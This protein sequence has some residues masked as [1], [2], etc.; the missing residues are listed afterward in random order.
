MAWTP[1]SMP[2]SRAW[3]SCI[4]GGGLF[5]AIA[6]DSNS[7]AYSLNGTQWTGA[8]T[9][10]TFNC[11]TNGNGTWVAGG[12][13]FIYYSTTGYSWTSVAVLINVL[14]VTFSNNTFVAGGSSGSLIY[15]STNG[16]TFL[17]QLL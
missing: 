10:L 4:Y 2:A 8:G 1:R 7:A 5:L 13:L 15:Y 9:S 12:N 6:S 14:G 17:W 16:S 3:K 11:I